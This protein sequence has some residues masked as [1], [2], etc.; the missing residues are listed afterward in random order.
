MILLASSHSTL[1]QTGQ[2]W[3][4]RAC[5]GPCPIRGRACSVLLML[6]LGRVCLL[7]VGTEGERERKR[8]NIAAEGENLAPV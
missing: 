1:A 2:I 5:R 3:C 6:S 7:A 8:I 4:F